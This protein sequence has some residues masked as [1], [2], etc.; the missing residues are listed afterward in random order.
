MKSLLP[1]LAFGF[2][3][4]ACDDMKGNLSVREEL[5]V[6]AKKTGLFQSGTKEARIPVGSYEAKLNPTSKT[7]MN[8]ELEVNGKDLKIPFK[9]P[10]GTQIPEFEGQV[11]VLAAESG[12]NYDL[13][14]DV[15]S[16]VSSMD[17]DVTETC[18]AGYIPVRR[19]VTHPG[20]TI[21]TTVPGRTECHTNRRG[22]R[23]CRNIPAGRH[24]RTT[25]PRTD[26]HM[27]SE[28]VYGTQRV[29]KRKT[30][31]VKNLVVDVAAAG[32]QVAQ[33]N[34]T[35]SSS[36]TATVNSSMCVR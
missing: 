19:C 34:H 31:T 16:N 6:K 10:E 11:D 36:S 5:T 2:L 12:Q 25:H 7:S 26:C 35:S 13:H 3:L 32:A 22:E 8:L 15:N 33:F 23:V 27:V 30:T 18:V 9:I 20:N 4:V 24:C 17:Y 14:A 1:V 29:T 28:A 21:C